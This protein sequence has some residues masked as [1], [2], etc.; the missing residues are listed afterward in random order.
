MAERIAARRA[1]RRVDELRRRADAITA[2][3]LYSNEPLIDV[4]IAINELRERVRDQWPDRVWLFDAVYGAR[5]RRLAE[6]GWT[7]PRRR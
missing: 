5:W 6:Q 2:R 4:Q 1:R 3:L 7:R